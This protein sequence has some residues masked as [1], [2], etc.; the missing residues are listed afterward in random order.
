MAIA[1]Q[2]NQLLQLDYTV[3]HRMLVMVGR[4]MRRLHFAGCIEAMPPLGQ[5]V[6][7]WD[8]FTV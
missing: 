1:A 3:L 2:M 5:E 6:L 8:I 4:D 7:A